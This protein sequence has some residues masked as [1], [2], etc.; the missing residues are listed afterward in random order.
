MGSARQHE[1]PRCLRVTQGLSYDVRPDGIPLYVANR[2]EEVRIVQRTGEEP[3]LPQMAA[4]AVE[5]VHIA[6][7]EVVRSANALG[8]RRL[9]QRRGHDMH[10]IGHQ[11]AGMNRQT[12][13]LGLGLEHV[14]I[15]AS[16]IIDEKDVLP[17][18]PPPVQYDAGHQR[19][20]PCLRAS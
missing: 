18:V 5:L 15:A 9:M 6:R 11:A 8:Q 3:V 1:P 17:V 7:I 19:P 16:I 20:Q 4:A 14:Q 2:R 13:L 10:V 12:I